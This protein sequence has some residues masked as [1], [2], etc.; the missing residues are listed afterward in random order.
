[1]DLTKEAATAVPTAGEITAPVNQSAVMTKYPDASSGRCLVFHSGWSGA[2]AARRSSA[3][4]PW[5]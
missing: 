3:K 4:R 1:M 5:P 2:I